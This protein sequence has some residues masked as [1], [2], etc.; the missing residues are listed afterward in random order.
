[1]KQHNDK[2]L[3]GCFKLAARDRVC[4][5]VK[6]GLLYNRAKILGQSFLQLVVLSSR[7]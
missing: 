1:M 2:S 6:G 7:S 3:D 5:V 4:F